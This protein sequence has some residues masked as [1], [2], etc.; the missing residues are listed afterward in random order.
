MAHIISKCTIVYIFHF[1]VY[2]ANDDPGPSQPK[3]SK[4]TTGDDTEVITKGFLKYFDDSFMEENPTSPSLPET[5]S[6]MVE[7]AEPV[8]ADDNREIP[9]DPIMAKVVETNKCKWFGKLYT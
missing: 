2:Y 3:K 4:I 7:R 9:K 8:A 1:L 6:A 5:E